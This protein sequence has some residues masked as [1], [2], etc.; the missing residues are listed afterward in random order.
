[1]TWPPTSRASAALLSFFVLFLGIPGPLRAQEEVR[2]VRLSV[3]RGVT[4]TVGLPQTVGTN[5]LAIQI[6]DSGLIPP[7]SIGAVG[8]TQVLAGANG[9]IRVFD[10]NGVMGALDTSRPHAPPRRLLTAC[11]TPMHTSRAFPL[12][13][14]AL[15]PA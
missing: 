7:D 5:F 11:T 2:G 13:R 14:A 12:H 6:I 3:K 1:M 8:P 15:T 9:R 4:E 10:K